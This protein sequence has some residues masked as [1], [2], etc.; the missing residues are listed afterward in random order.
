LC[1]RIQCIAC[2]DDTFRDCATSSFRYVVCSLCFASDIV[3]AFNEN[4]GRALR[5]RIVG[6]VRCATN[7][8]FWFSFSNSPNAYV[9]VLKKTSRRFDPRGATPSSPKQIPVHTLFTRFAMLR[10]SYNAT[11]LAR[12]SSSL[13]PIHSTTGGRSISTA[14]GRIVTANTSDP[15]SLEVS[16][17][18]GARYNLHSLWL[19]DA[20]RDASHVEGTAPFFS[21]LAIFKLRKWPT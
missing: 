2:E 15:S 18:D 4:K 10:V 17:D 7:A 1:R 14:G 12:I 11:R 21:Q 9:Y 5:I 8:K 19:R 20:C 16:F 6:F 13:N 3:S